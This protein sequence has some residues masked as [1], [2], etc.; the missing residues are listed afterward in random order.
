MN[1]KGY[2][3]KNVIAKL[4]KA[5]VLHHPFCTIMDISNFLETNEF[6]INLAC[7]PRK[8]RSIIIEFNQKNYYWFNIVKEK[9][10]PCRYVV[11]E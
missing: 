7:T 10:N 8:V 2:G 11:R 5:Y 9:E 6:G 3:K 4:I 1:G